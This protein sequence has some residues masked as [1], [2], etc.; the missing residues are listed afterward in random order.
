MAEQQQW[1]L[2]EIFAKKRSLEDIFMSLTD[3][4]SVSSNRSEQALQQEER[5]D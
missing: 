2:Y 1:G 5:I 4:E 3:V